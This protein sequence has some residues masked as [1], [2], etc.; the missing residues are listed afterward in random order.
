MLKVFDQW[1]KERSNAVLKESYS[2][3][4]VINEDLDF[5]LVRFVAEV[6]KE[7]GLW[8]RLAIYEMLISI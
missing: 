6:R 8:E 5:A 4:P 2:G 7:G 1:K 3:E